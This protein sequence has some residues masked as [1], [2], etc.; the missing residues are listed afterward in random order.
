VLSLSYA[1]VGIAKFAAIFLPDT[2]SPNTYAMFLVGVTTLYTAFFLMMLFK[3]ILVSMAGPAPN[4]D[5]QRIL[6]AK[7]AREASLMSGLVTVVLF[8]KEQR[9]PQRRLEC[10]GWHRLAN[11]HR[12]VADLS[13]HTQLARRH[14]GGGDHFSDQS[15]SQIHVVRQI[16]FL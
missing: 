8:F 9:F 4:Y 15:D 2:F 11:G 10:C 3:G 6:A 13:S 16:V 7:N 1:F 14:S 12:G 5:M